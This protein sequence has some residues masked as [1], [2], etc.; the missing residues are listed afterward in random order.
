MT[1]DLSTIS[2]AELGRAYASGEIAPLAAA[3]WYLDRIANAD[4]PA[5]FLCITRERALGE[6]AEST[7]RYRNGAPL[8]PLDG[9]PIAWKDLFDV[10]GTVTTAGSDV[11][12]HAPPAAEDA[13]CVQLAAQAGLVSVGKVNLSEFAY[14]GLGLNPH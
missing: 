1:L 2:A 10:A 4:D 8:G 5:V 13:P 3:E 14:S 6:A 11:Y 7:K 12:R 9:V